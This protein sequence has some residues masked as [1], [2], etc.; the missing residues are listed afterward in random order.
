M[1]N[2][3]LIIHLIIIVV[4]ILLILIQKTGSDGL[5]GL[6]GGGSNNALFSVRGKANVL[7]KATG[8]LA[9]GFFVTSLTLAY[10][11]THKTSG[12]IVDQIKTEQISPVLDQ[13]NPANNTKSEVP[14]PATET[15]PAE[16]QVPLAK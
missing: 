14:A 8:F 2:I 4:M 7:T 11:A 16:P 5:S 15:K 3:I 10:L 6:S 1:E 9:L 13:K 12:S